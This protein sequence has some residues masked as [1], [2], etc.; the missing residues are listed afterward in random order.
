MFDRSLILRLRRAPV[1]DVRGFALLGG[2]EAM[3]RGILITVMPL[4]V[5]RAFPD[6]GTVSEI[7]FSVGVMSLIAGMMVP[8]LTRYVPRRWTFTCG[9]GL[10]VLGN[11]LAIIGGPLLAFGVLCNAIATVTV[12]ICFN[13]YVLDYIAKAE[14]GRS[15]TLRVFYSGLAWTIG[16]VT[17]VWLLDIWRPAPFLVSMAA[18]IVLLGVFWIMRLGNGR[19]IAKARALTPNPLAY[20]GRF[21]AQPRLIAGW[22]FAVIRSCG[23][24]TYVV[25]VP[26]FAIEAGLGD[27]IGGMMQSTTNAFLF[28][29]PLM[30]RWMQ[31]KSVRT[32]V[33]TGFFASA[34]LFVAATVFSPIPS[35]TLAF[36]MAGSV[37]LVLLDIAA[38]LPFLLAVKP[39]ER[40]EMAA[41]FS[42]FRDVSG[43]ATPA[44]AWLVLLVAPL[45]GV[46]AAT[47]LALLGAGMLA[48]RQH[49]QLGIRASDRIR[50]RLPVA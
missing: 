38:S 32:A 46:F 3:V 2:I 20:L 48:S 28:T 37:F 33:R 1:A 25:Y 44:A 36:M 12:Y 11:S 27:K 21:F 42:S 41:V 24:W 18:A 31:K 26:I 9:A 7:Y 43:I 19:I 40:T 13:A 10:F 15:E 4:S 49:P 6:S 14:L 5:Y 23:W 30:L 8:Q 34:G 35:A 45:A 29:T 47:G 22:L 17:G 39:S 16:P 50:R